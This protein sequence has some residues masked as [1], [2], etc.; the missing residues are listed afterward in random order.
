MPPKSSSPYRGSTKRSRGIALRHIGADLVHPSSVSER[1]RQG[2]VT[3]RS[4]VDSGSAKPIPTEFVMRIPR[5]PSTTADVQGNTPGGGQTSLFDIR[6]CRLRRHE[7]FCQRARAPAASCEDTNGGTYPL[8]LAPQK[9]GA[10]ASL[11]QLVRAGGCRPQGREFRPSRQRLPTNL[12]S[13]VRRGHGTRPMGWRSRRAAVGPVCLAAT[14]N[15]AGP[16]AIW[17]PEAPNQ[18]LESSF[19]SRKA[20]QRL[21]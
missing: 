17:R 15:A 3:T 13:A 1:V 12:R 7:P 21:P 16:P 10:C 8:F 14:T 20:G 4:I 11:A 6:I 5:V 2:W 19:C 9:L 18:G